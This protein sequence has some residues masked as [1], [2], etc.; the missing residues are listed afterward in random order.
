MLP[1]K[2][3]S[4][5]RIRD[6]FP[7][8]D[9]GQTS[10]R[11]V[12]GD[13][14]EVEADVFAEGAEPAFA[15]LVWR[16]ND[17]RRWR[18]V[19][20]VPIGNDRFRSSFEVPEAGNYGYTVRGWTDPALG[21]L[22]R[23]ERRVASD[24]VR[25]VDLEEGALLLGL[26]RSR[27]DDELKGT[28]V[29]KT[30]RDRLREATVLL[31]TEGTPPME[32]ARAVLGL[33]LPTLLQTN[34][35]Q[36][37]V[38]AYGPELPLV[39]DPPRAGRSAWYEL[40]PRST[41]PDPR[42]PGTLQDVIERLPYV[43]KLGFDVLYLPPIHPI[44]RTGR[45]GGNNREQAK[46][47]EP[48]SPWAIGSENGGHEAVHP[49]LGT[50]DDLRNLVASARDL[51]IDVAL[52]L[53]FQCSPDHP[54]VKAHPS[55]FERLPD[56]TLRTA[57]NPPKRYQDVLPL[58]FSTPDWRSLWEAL[59]DVVLFWVD[60]GIR[61]FRVDNPHTKPFAF[62]EW[63]IS[64]VHRKHPEVLFLAEAFTRPK[65]MYELAKVGFTHSYTYFTWRT[66]KTELTEYFRELYESPVAQYFRPHL[67]PNTPDILPHH[68]QTPETRV[69]ESRF[70]LAATLSSHYGIYGPAFEKGR[71]KA[72][73]PD[74]EDYLDSEK[75]QREVWSKDPEGKLPALIESVNRARKENPALTRGRHLTFHGVDNDQIIAY[76]RVTDDR[77]NQVLCIINLDPAHR[78]AGWTALDLDALGTGGTASFDLEDLLTGART[79]WK[80]ASNHLEMRHDGPVGHLY[81]VRVPG[82]DE[83][84]VSGHP[85][86]ASTISSIPSAGGRAGKERPSGP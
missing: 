36:G 40:F 83:A 30:A 9:A 46:E 33:G 81:R 48:G 67:W 21:W 24:A 59:R 11:R 41:S 29:G 12:P 39:V 23:L 2:R 70:L 15:S 53:A 86:A 31:R 42:R 25:S 34:V 73:A 4:R 79:T 55:W 7:S 58:D 77:S 69:F 56:G 14:L 63:L 71:H 75:Y 20:M 44:G 49:E 6:L 47:G 13:R 45:K 8:I 66:T 84:V 1:G 64:E 27:T 80:G 68:L 85:S 43:A 65:V 72:V 37:T 32:R 62:W 19:P 10:V 76:S 26:R 16:R 22:S 82:H 50:V 18:P 60:Q 28:S 78:Q 74:S 51:G 17:E 61:W 38:F 3:P 54:W 5:V 57:E 52:D 35:P